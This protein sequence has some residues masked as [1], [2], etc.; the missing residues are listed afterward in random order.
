MPATQISFLDFAQSQAQALQ[1]ASSCTLPTVA[2]HA[3][4]PVVAHG[5]DSG[6]ECIRVL[7][8]DE[9]DVLGWLA[10][11]LCV[12]H[13]TYSNGAYVLLALSH[14]HGGCNGNFSNSDRVASY[15]RLLSV[16]ALCI[17][18]GC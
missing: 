4:A 8:A 16:S 2:V 15:E 12:S 3:P 18:A 9:C 17:G 14:A 1:A 7:S 5:G 6:G 13:G 10:H 11:D